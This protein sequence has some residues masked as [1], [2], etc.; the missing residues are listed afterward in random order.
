MVWALRRKRR[1]A[2]FDG[3]F[4]L[5]EVA[6]RTLGRPFFV[7]VSFL[8]AILAFGVENFVKFPQLFFRE[9]F[10]VAG[11]AFELI[12]RHL[13]NGLGGTGLVFLVMMA[14]AALKAQGRMG[15]MVEPGWLFALDGDLFGRGGQSCG[16]GDAGCVG[17]YH[18]G[19]AT[20]GDGKQY[21]LHDLSPF[22]L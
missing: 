9:I 18:G 8:M 7:V 2:A 11:G 22:I 4:A 13:P 20:D 3:L 19:G 6:A 15:G 14:G 1:L 10:V 16:L 17:R 5:F 21:F 12:R